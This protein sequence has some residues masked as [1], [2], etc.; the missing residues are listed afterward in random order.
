MLI[1]KKLYVIGC[2]SVIL[3]NSDNNIINDADFYDFQVYLPSSLPSTKGEEVIQ[4]FPP[5]G[6][7][8]GGKRK[9]KSLICYKN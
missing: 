9:K 8:K 6:K 3:H 5:W 1:N 7:M 2:V 4:T